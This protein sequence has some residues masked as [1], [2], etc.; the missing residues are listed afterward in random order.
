MRIEAKHSHNITVRC[1]CNRTF[2]LIRL[3]PS[4]ECPHC[5]RTAISTD[6]VLEWHLAGGKKVSVDAA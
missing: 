6:L 4:V 1:D 2:N 3:G 5:G